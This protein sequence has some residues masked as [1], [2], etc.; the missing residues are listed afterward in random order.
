MYNR[1]I[2]NKL[3][4]NQM[5]KETLFSAMSTVSGN[6]FVGLDMV[7]TVKLK[8]GKKNE[9][10]GRVQKQITGAVIQVFQNKGVNGYEAMVKRRLVA[11]GKSAEDFTLGERAWGKRIDNMPI[12]EHT[13]DGDTKYYV[14][15]IFQQVGEVQYLLDGKPVALEDIEGLDAPSSS[16][17]GQG[18]L[19]NK[20]AI[21]TIDVQ[22]IKTM[23]VNGASYS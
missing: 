12:V 4:G 3:K 11:E 20:V 16:S 14:E 19:D 6:T 17:T 1:Y 22:N 13:K 5:K 7:S 9:Q 15:G 10:Q 21:R 23:R 2:D 8:G 18:G